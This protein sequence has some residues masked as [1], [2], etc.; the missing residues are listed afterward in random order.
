MVLRC[1]APWSLVCVLGLFT[2]IGALCR[3]AACDAVPSASSALVQRK[4]LV[5]GRPDMTRWFLG[6]N[7]NGGHMR[8]VSTNNRRI[9]A[10]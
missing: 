2:K 8:R 4:L 1:G 7:A 6:G 10:I 9:I 5:A 3:D